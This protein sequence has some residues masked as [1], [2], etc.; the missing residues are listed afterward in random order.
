MSVW[1][2]MYLSRRIRHIARTVSAVEDVDLTV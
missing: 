2:R 1:D